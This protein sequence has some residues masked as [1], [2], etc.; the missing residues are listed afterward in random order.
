MKGPRHPKIVESPGTCGACTH[1][2]RG[3]NGEALMATGSCAIKPDRWSYSQR[4]K[5]CKLYQE[6][7]KTDEHKKLP[8]N[9]R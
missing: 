3:H 8:E 2:K 6:K 9:Q 7:E 1:F 4:V 5:A